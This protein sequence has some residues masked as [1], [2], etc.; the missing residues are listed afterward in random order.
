MSVGD[1]NR[2]RSYANRWRKEKGKRVRHIGIRFVMEVGD[3]IYPTDKELYPSGCAVSLID[4][5]T[6]EASSLDVS[7]IDAYQVLD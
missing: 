2:H 7:H 6:G 3:I 1:A 5:K 4:R